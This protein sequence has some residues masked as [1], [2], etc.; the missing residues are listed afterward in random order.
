VALVLL[1]DLGWMADLR[2]SRDERLSCAD[3][4]RS[5]GERN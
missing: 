3:C 4:R 1:V 5:P 2:Q